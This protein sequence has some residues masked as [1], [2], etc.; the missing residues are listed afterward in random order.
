[1]KMFSIEFKTTFVNLSLTNTEKL[2]NGVTE[3]V[4]RSASIGYSENFA[5]DSVNFGDI[6][7][8]FQ[9]DFQNYADYYHY[10]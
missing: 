8:Y 4:K 1:M 6:F 5:Q 10:S 3:S 2:K 9:S 7:N